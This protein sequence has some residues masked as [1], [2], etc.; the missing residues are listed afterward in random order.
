MMKSFAVLLTLWA[1]SVNG[2]SYV[3]DPNIT[4]GVAPSECS[5]FFPFLFDVDRPN[6]VTIC[7][8]NYAVIYDTDCKI[9]LLVFENLLA[10][11]IDGIIPRSNN[12]KPDPNLH[13]VDSATLR[14]YYHSSY[15]RGH[16]A[17][18][19]DMREDTASMSQ[20]FYLSNII[21][22]N[23]NVNRGAWRYL[24]EYDRAVVTSNGETPTYIITG[25]VL[26]QLPVRIGGGV[27]VPSYTF[28]IILSNQSIEA[29]MIDNRHSASSTQVIDHRSS[30][31]AIMLR[32]GYRFFN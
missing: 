17:P 31:R 19:G 21:P 29:F 26:P 10:S 23:P 7:R 25:A 12:F 6:V 9:P 2:Q 8:I 15:D 3:A 13:P 18:A 22:Q 14:D 24:E 16:M 4:D 28:K 11:E 20:S 5:E 1:T 32:S 27:C 30:L